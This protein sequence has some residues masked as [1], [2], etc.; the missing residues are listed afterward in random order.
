MGFVGSI[1]TRAILENPASFSSLFILGT[2][3]T[4]F[5]LSMRTFYN[6]YLSQG[7]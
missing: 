6:V 4:N 5:V 2:V 3:I 1:E 7:H